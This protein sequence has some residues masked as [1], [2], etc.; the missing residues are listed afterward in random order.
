[1]YI[2]VN[3]AY[4][5][6]MF[7]WHTMAFMHPSM[8]R[9]Y[10]AALV[11]S[12]D[13]IPA[14]V[15]RRMNTTQQRIN[16]WETRGVSQEG[17]IEAE[18][19]YGVSPRWILDGTGNPPTKP[20]DVQNI[21][22]VNTVYPAVPL[23]SWVKAGM[24]AE[25][26]DNYLPGSPDDLRPAYTSRPSKQSFALRVEGDSMVS[27]NHTSFPEGTILIVDPLRAPCAG[28]YV[29]AK[30]V[31]TQQATFKRLMQD[32]GRW[33]LKPLNPA[34]PII[35]IDDPAIRVIGVVIESQNVNKL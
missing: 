20:G 22:P 10:Q 28:D 5:N 33:F 8:K 32:G 15:A 29:I 13:T 17:A 4:N 12:G 31:D 21:A 18:R 2:S 19:A 9:L 34:Y 25:I 27:H 30:D 6:R 14:D 7:T 3:V 1:M 23:I 24:W 26:V 35:P 16:N 11:V